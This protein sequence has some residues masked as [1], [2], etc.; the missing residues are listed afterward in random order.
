[1]TQQCCLALLLVAV[2]PNFVLHAFLRVLFLFTKGFAQM[3][4]EKCSVKSSNHKTNSGWLQESWK[5][6]GR[7]LAACPPSRC[8]ELVITL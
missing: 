5:S 6:G 2:L 1:M 4:L 8:L 7:G 3:F